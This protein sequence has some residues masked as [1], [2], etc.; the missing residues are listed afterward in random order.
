MTNN[1]I[2]L[3]SNEPCSIGYVSARVFAIGKSHAPA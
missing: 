2:M 3:Y 1:L